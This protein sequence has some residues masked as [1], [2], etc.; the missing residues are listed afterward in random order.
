MVSLIYTVT[1]R[2]GEIYYL[3]LQLYHLKESTSYKDI[4]AMDGEK[5]ALFR[6]ACRRKVLLADAMDCKS[7]LREG[8]QSNFIPLAELFATILFYRF[9]N[10]RNTYTE[11]LDNMLKAKRVLSLLSDTKL[12]SVS[13]CSKR[14]NVRRI[15]AKVLSAKI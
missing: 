11:K 1:P 10:P 6:E 13:N 12:S 3:P 2:Q 4:A 5:C 14:R 8:F 9:S 15:R 7:T